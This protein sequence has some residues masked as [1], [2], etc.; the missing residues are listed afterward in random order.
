MD[1]KTTE[2]Q[3]GE[4]VKC[5]KCGHKNPAGDDRCGRCNASLTVV[6]SECGHSNPRIRSRCTQCD[7]RLHRRFWR[8]RYHLPKVP[9]LPS[10]FG[11][12]HLIIV[13]VA[14]Y[15]LYRLFRW[16]VDAD[17]TPVEL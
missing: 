2:T 5:A 15:V 9:F 17:F 11:P 16:L 6:C 7:T 1:A 10:A 3:A 14:L 12:L 13:V 4:P 8:L